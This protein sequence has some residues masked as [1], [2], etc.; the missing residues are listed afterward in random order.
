MVLKDNTMSDNF[1]PNDDNQNFSHVS[2]WYNQ[3]SAAA[4]QNV[5]LQLPFGVTI[6]RLMLRLIGWNKKPLG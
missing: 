5:R 6:A 4:L 3:G 1:I 2:D